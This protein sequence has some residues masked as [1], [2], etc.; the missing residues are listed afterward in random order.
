MLHIYKP[1]VFKVFNLPKVSVVD[2]FIVKSE[3]HSDLAR[4]DKKEN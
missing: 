4:E 3:K 2:S 1:Q